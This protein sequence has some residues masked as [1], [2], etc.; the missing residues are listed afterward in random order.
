VPFVGKDVPS[1]SSEFA[2]PDIVIGLSIL[3]YRYE[4]LRQRDFGLV[5]QS[6]RR[7]LSQGSSVFRRAAQARWAKWVESVGGRVRGSSR[8]QDEAAK[9]RKEKS[10]AR[11]RARSDSKTSSPKSTSKDSDTFDLIDWF[12]EPEDA[13]ATHDGGDEA[14]EAGAAGNCAALGAGAAHAAPDG[15]EVVKADFDDLVQNIWALEMVNI[16]SMEQMAMLWPL[17]RALPEAIQYHLNHTVFPTVTPHQ[18]SKLYACGQVL[19]SDSIYNLRLGFSGTPSDLLPV[20][21]QP[22]RYEA[23]SDG[24]ML[25]TLTDPAVCTATHLAPKVR[26]SFLLFAQFFMCC[27][28]LLYSICSFFC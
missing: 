17:L 26:S 13:A 25:A 15:V 11:A 18:G 28:Y 22:C 7:Q 3:A 27:S 21:L 16:G 20:E 6:L 9:R 2:H 14:E 10:K 1:R 23:G 24:R 19:G 12:N 5:V 4:G 8:G